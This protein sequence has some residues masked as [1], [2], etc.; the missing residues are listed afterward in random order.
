V[1]ASGQLRQV[2]DR[3]I[4][5]SVNRYDRVKSIEG[6]PPDEGKGA[7]MAR[8][9]TPVDDD[10]ELEFETLD[11]VEG[12]DKPETDEVDDNDG[13][14]SAKEAAK[15]IGTDARM[16][17]KFLRSEKGLVGQG[18]RW[19]IDEDAIDDLKARFEAW[20]KGKKISADKPAKKEPKVVVAKLK[21]AL[22]PDA[23]DELEELDELEGPADDELDD[24]D[25]GFEDM[26]FEEVDD[27][28][29]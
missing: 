16:L 23:D 8:K 17:R 2:E 4:L 21:E 22:L 3:K 11:E 28:T 25:E 6:N 29:E 14:L 15:L 7:M 18:N 5:T 27:D 12:T 9:V 19:Q 10:E 1:A 20:G 24:E 13:A 26:E